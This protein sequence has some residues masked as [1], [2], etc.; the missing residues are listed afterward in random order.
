M[1]LYPLLDDGPFKSYRD[2]L[3]PSCLTRP[4]H[5][6]QQPGAVTVAVTA[7]IPVLMEAALEADL[8]RRS[9]FRDL[10]QN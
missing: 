10:K 6:R 1:P 8:V 9:I 3:S 7:C 4:Y 5:E 2:L